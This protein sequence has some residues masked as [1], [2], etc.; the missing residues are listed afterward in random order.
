M[1]EHAHCPHAAIIITR[2]YKL[3][4]TPNAYYFEDRFELNAVTRIIPDRDYRGI[5]RYADRI[6]YGNQR[7]QTG[8]R[9]IWDRVKLQTLIWHRDAYGQFLHNGQIKIQKRGIA[10]IT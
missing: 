10:W 9:V 6:I 7:G 1:P 4:D 3:L 5:T 8:L 2:D